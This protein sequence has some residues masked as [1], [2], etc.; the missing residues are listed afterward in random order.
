M[1]R[2]DIPSEINAEAHDG[3]GGDLVEDG[4]HER[5]LPERDGDTLPDVDTAL[6]LRHDQL[7]IEALSKRRYEEVYYHNHNALKVKQVRESGKAMKRRARF[8]WE[9]ERN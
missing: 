8:K 4:R 7:L 1:L 6:I 2:C 3:H 5:V 9:G